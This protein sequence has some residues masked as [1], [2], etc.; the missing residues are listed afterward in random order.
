[1]WFLDRFV[2]GANYID[3]YGGDAVWIIMDYLDIA[4][5]E[6]V[7]NLI[8]VNSTSDNTEVNYIRIVSELLR[9]HATNNV[10]NDA[11]EEFQVMPQGK[12]QKTTR[13]HD[14]LVAKANRIGPYFDA[15]DLLNIFISGIDDSIT[16]TVQQRY[17]NQAA[18]FRQNNM[19]PTDLHL[20]KVLRN[21]AMYADTLRREN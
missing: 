13:F 21:L 8:G 2:L 14:K 10:L 9:R 18:T 11:T 6:M 19:T 12:N 1:M 5:K 15:G 4:P 7:F 3:V 20:N 16:S 17:K